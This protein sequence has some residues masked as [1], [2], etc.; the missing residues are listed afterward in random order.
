MKKKVFF[1]NFLP[2]IIA[3]VGAFIFFTAYNRYLLDSSLVNLKVSLRKIEG[4]KSLA[5]AKEVKDILDTAFLME[6]TKDDFD[7]ASALKIEIGA[8]MI[9]EIPLEKQAKNEKYIASM[10]ASATIDAASDMVS[11]F[12]QTS[13]VED[14]KYFIKE[15]IAKKK[16]GKP[17][18]VS[19]LEDLIIA[20]VP[21]RKRGELKNLRKVIA[22]NKKNLGSYSGKRLQDEYLKIAQLY[23]RIKDY[24]SSLDYI[25]KTIN[26]DPGSPQALKAQF[27]SGILYKVK[28]DFK[29]ARAVFSQIKEK[30]PDEWGGFSAYQEASSLYALGETEEA[31]TLFKKNFNENPSQQTSQIAQ[32]RVGQIY[33]HDLDD[34]RA[35]GEAFNKLEAKAKGSELGDYYDKKV[36]K[37]VTAYYSYQGFQL[38][39][40]GYKI[41]NFEK[42][43]EALRQFDLAL[44]IS[45][46]SDLAYS[47]KSLAYS[48]MNNSVRA[49]E[50]AEKARRLSSRGIES[51]IVLGFIYHNLGMIDKAIAEYQEAAEA[52]PDWDLCQ[53]NLGTIHLLRKDYSQAKKYFRQAIKANPNFAHAHNNLGYVYWAE[54]NYRKAKQSFRKAISLEAGYVDPYYNLGVILAALGD[55]E[56]A[57]KAFV[58]VEGLRAEYMKTKYYLDRIKE[59]LG[60]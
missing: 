3:L 35:A 22:K 13:Q 54:R 34:P 5:E 44:G 18:L 59:R 55:Y 9:E 50:E 53:Y 41:S 23:L 33:L 38:L 43:N 6:A 49:L 52:N 8:Q 46:D 58:K 28:K 51:V 7:L 40:E 11:D 39:K 48:L 14:A 12:S 4:S 15:L 30:L 42:Y 26:I 31:I 60:Y 21:S 47:G 27:Y 25:N 20:V 56:E 17:F 32:F 2:L 36:K 24:A 1:K 10:T 16:K 37:D 57:R 45:Y 29:K 19:K